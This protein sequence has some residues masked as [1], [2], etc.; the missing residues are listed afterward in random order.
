MEICKLK[1]MPMIGDFERRLFR[2]LDFSLLSL[3]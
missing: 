3:Q 2:T 1:K